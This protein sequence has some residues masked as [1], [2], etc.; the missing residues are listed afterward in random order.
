VAFGTDAPL[1]ALDPWPGIAMAVLRR[2]PTWGDEASTFG[3]REAITIE[4]ALRASTV[5]VAATAKDQL[6]G[7]LVPGSAADLI[8]LPAEP[9]EERLR[10]AD[11][12]DLRPRLVLLDGETAF[13]R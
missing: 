10:G 11:F 1:V 6:G 2:D 9:D 5:G 3:A 4:Q 8:V 12:S 13:E 7:R